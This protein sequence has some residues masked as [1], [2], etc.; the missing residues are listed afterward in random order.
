M[1]QDRIPPK[2]QMFPAAKQRRM[3]VL[4]DKNSEGTIT[5]REK[6]LLKKLVAEAEALTIANGKRLA[7]FAQQSAIPANSV[8]VTVWVS[9]ASSPR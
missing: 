8:P 1:I 6:A 4:L 3:D 5:P 9:P 2:I 7:A